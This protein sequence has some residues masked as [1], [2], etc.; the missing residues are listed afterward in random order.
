MGDLLHFPN[1]KPSPMQSEAVVYTEDELRVLNEINAVTSYE[2]KFATEADL[3]VA[4]AL[5][6]LRQ[7]KQG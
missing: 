6:R 1:S 3:E 7:S 4:K 2:R 5:L